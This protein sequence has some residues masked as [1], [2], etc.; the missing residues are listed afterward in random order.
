MFVPGE[1][2]AA[3]STQP[4]VC[5]DGSRVSS[6]RPTSANPELS[7]PSQAQS[8]GEGA[9]TGPREAAAATVGG[10]ERSGLCAI[11]GPRGNRRVTWSPVGGLVHTHRRPRQLHL[12][13]GLRAGEWVQKSPR[14]MA[15]SL[16]PGKPVVTSLAPL[17]QSTPHSRTP[18]LTAGPPGL[19]GLGGQKP[20]CS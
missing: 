19:A 4:V 5:S 20:G 18:R 10:G 3:F 13:G 14:Q 12:S 11:V 9:G 2:R 15:R 17:V 7:A 1:I 6:S 16:A 8:R